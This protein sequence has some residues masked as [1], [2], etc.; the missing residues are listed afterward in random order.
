MK[1]LSLILMLVMAVGLAY[2]DPVSISDPLT[3]ITGTGGV[4][5]N[6]EDSE[7]VAQ[8]AAIGL[9]PAIIYGGGD[10][11]ADPGGTDSWEKVVFTASGATFGL[12]YGGD[13]GRNYIRTID[14]TYNTVPFE[15]YVTVNGTVDAQ[16]AFVGMGAG[17][18]GDWGVPDWNAAGVDA[19]FSEVRSANS[20][21]WLQDDGVST[22]VA[23]DGTGDG[24]HRI[25]LAY[26][27]ETQIASVSVDTDYNGTFAAD[28]VVDTVST[29]GL[30]TNGEECRIYFGADDG[31]VF[32][33][34]DIVSDSLVAQDPAPTDGE[35]L[36]DKN[37]VTLSWNAPE[38]YVPTEYKISI[39]S[40]DPNFANPPQL[41]DGDS[42]TPTADPTSY[43]AGDLSFE[44]EYF[45]RVDTSD[46]GTWYEGKVWSFTTA[47]AIPVV[48]TDPVSQTIADGGTAVFTVVA[49]NAGTYQWYFDAAAIG[50]A[51]SDTLTVTGVDLSDEGEYYCVVS[52]T[53]GINV[54]SAIA[55]LWNARLMAAW[56]FDGT[57]DSA[58]GVW[59]GTYT[60]PNEA[61]IVA[62][63]EAFDTGI[64]GDAVVLP[65][66][67]KHVLVEGSEEYFNFYTNGFTVSA[68]INSD[69]TDAYQAVISKTIDGRGTGFGLSYHFG[70]A[71]LALRGGFSE[72]W[73]G[74]T[75]GSEWHLIVGA[76][77]PAAETLKVY[78]DG[79]LAGTVNNASGV[80]PATIAPVMF[81]VETPSGDAPYNGLVDEV[82]IWS[83]AVDA[84]DLAHMY[85]DV[86]T[87]ET[88]CVDQ[89][90]LE[91]DVAGGPL[92]EEGN[93]TGDCRINLAD[94]AVFAATWANCNSVPDCN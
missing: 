57:L 45:W 42:V 89:V 93:P 63:Q 91:F 48:L 13:N 7:T 65:G 33:D 70:Q 34:L 62:G 82:K 11:V 92:D 60:D 36:I 50:G 87:E 71:A 64:I 46:N 26:D 61:N 88:V 30:W 38:D 74:A 20:T 76:Y 23:G 77:D 10:G 31:M 49:Q 16:N 52:N 81:G 54:P 78:V 32:T 83:Y 75:T 56:T 68:W 6:T 21:V 90:G 18:K 2:G 29:A 27:P 51:T 84:Y 67:G 85:T 35:D 73:S 1:K 25:C 86:M 8:L 39:R 59:A 43:A 40:G 53:T 15:A 44:T 66:D 28:F 9:E 94:F 12:G 24:T 41:V 5:G 3:G 58:D 69:V 72:A 17:V 37:G 47:P 4:D 19:V 55:N 22:S 14:T 80:A 79:L